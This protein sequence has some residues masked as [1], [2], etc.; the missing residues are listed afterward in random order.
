M[1]TIISIKDYLPAIISTRR[2]VDVLDIS[3]L[4]KYN[5]YV[6]DFSDISFISR[7]FADEFINQIKKY[8]IN[9]SLK[10]ANSNV[11]NMIKAVK[12]SQENKRTDIDHVAITTF[13]NNEELNQFLY[14]I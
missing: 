14:T 8:S 4:D 10:H 1:K 11:K 3:S 2:A 12:H 6:F 5:E 9:Y 13:R 7:S